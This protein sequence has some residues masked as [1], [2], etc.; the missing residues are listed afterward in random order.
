MTK[1]FVSTSLAGPTSNQTPST[2]CIHRLFLGKHKLMNPLTGLVDCHF[3][4]S[5]LPY[6]SFRQRPRSVPI[7]LIPQKLGVYAQKITDND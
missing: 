4:L 2:N 3:S 1:I 5:W 6:T 7:L